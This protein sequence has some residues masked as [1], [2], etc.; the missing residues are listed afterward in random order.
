M[1][2]VRWWVRY[3]RYCAC[4]PTDLCSARLWGARKEVSLRSSHSKRPIGAALL[5][6]AL[7]ATACGRVAQPAASEG[8]PSEAPMTP[9]PEAYS[10]PESA[11]LASPPIAAWSGD[12]TWDLSGED[13]DRI[14]FA[15]TNGWTS[16]AEVAGLPRMPEPC[17]SFELGEGHTYPRE[18]CLYPVLRQMV[19]E[20]AFAFYMEYGNL[21]LGLR[22]SE[23]LQVA[24]MWVPEGN[25]ANDP[26]GYRL[27]RTPEGF[28][29]PEPGDWAPYATA[30]IEAYESETF[31]R[32]YAATPTNEA[33]P[34]TYWFYGAEV[35]L[36]EATGSGWSVSTTRTLSSGCHGCALEFAAVFVLD[37]TSD[38]APST[39]RFEGFCHYDREVNRRPWW[40]EEALAALRTDLPLCS[41]DNPW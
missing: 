25:N 3:R 36:P 31:A 9:P 14:M 19:S 20:N 13:T 30:L 26:A 27:I 7:L 1:K 24:D 5:A 28:L 10:L 6:A 4:R 41:P 37:F 22:G 35:G 29:S 8:D 21:V 34:S 17:Y 18:D 23:P 38:G 16:D 12:P 40:D 15:Y 11:M 2:A 39:A 33:Q 32:I